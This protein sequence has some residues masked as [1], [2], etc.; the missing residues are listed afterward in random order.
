MN[1]ARH[2]FVSFLAGLGSCLMPSLA[3]ADPPDAVVRRPDH[4]FAV[5]PPEGWT[6]VEQEV[7]GAMKLSFR[8]PGTIGETTV[9]IESAPRGEVRSAAQMVDTAR[10]FAETRADYTQR[11]YGRI[12]LGRD[13]P[14]IEV[15]IERTGTTYCLRQVY[16]IEGDRR[17]TL[18]CHA[19]KRSFA[20][21]EPSFDATFDSLAVL[22]IPESARADARM[23]EL[24]ARCGRELGWVGSWDE[25]AT[26]ARAHRKLVLVY[27]RQHS[28]IAVTDA[29]FVG[30]FMDPEF[31]DLV[32]ER[33]VA[34]R[35]APT[36]PSPLRD[37]AKYGLGPH[38]FGQSVL[39]VTPDGDVVRD[40]ALHDV[41]ALHDVLIDALRRRP[42]FTGEPPA[43]DA[44]P[45][46]RARACLRRGELA[47]A[48]RLVRGDESGEA[49]RVRAAVHRRLRECDAAI[50]SIEAA[51]VQAGGGDPDLDVEEALVR[52]RR[53]ETASAERLLRRALEGDVAFARRTEAEYLLGAFELSGER[54]AD[55]VTRWTRLIET[56]PDDRWAWKAA[57]MMTSSTFE[58]GLGEDFRWPDESVLA[59]ARVPAGGVL[60]VERSRS[61]RRSAIEFLLSR[62]REDG[63]WVSPT[64]LGD[65]ERKRPNPFTRAI[66]AIC[67]QALLAVEGDA[68]SRAVAKA[69]EYLRGAERTA[70]A[71]A[72]PAFV[73]DYTVWS[74]AYV[75]WFLADA[76]ERGAFEGDRDLMTA[77]VDDLAKKQRTGGGWSYLIATSVSATEETL[78]ISISFLTAPV[79]IALTRARD[80]GV[81]IPAG[82]LDRALSCLE[83]MRNDDGTFE[84]ML[85]HESEDAARTT[86]RPG[87]AGRGPV[88]TLALLR[89][90]RASL[91]DLRAALDLFVEH[92][93]LFAREQ[94]KTLMHAG[95]DG[96][97]SH[98]L[99]FDYATAA[100]AVAALPGPERGRYRDVILDVLMRAR[101]ADGAFLDNPMIGREFGA[102]AAL[103]TMELLAPLPY[104]EL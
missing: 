73:M 94:G 30:P 63:S 75:L 47:E 12:V 34:V 53:G 42:E 99:L 86:N 13:A 44:A 43:A 100:E 48:A 97:G 102:G 17:F 40:A 27:I 87:A 58:I 24:A 29:M 65:P 41:T 33:Y 6:M 32:R 83:R 38:T 36:D 67:G 56:D 72:T 14:G 2:A 51:R 71:D 18:E 85:N 1:C 22:E 57:G 79:A 31:V 49:H 52:A 19:P 37:A 89:H 84:Y 90:G 80:A 95:P 11:A 68:A 5:R 16:V 76:Q 69:I 7:G 3:I 60:P 59:S 96:Q 92:L 93:E 70:L 23:H 45:I 77:L 10:R 39:L 8:P 26:V 9:S 25:A 55:A 61:A 101:T 46:D 54:R 98:Y 35:L 50:A 81:E 64:E 20:A 15:D 66:T 62:Q 88:C 4:G 74:D 103:R 82:M 21:Y 78:P 28:G 104:E 91:D